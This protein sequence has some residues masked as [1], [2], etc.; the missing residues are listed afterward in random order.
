MRQ[1]IKVR[2]VGALGVE[3]SKPNLINILRNTLQQVEGETVDNQSA[4]SELKKQIA[5]SIAEMQLVKDTRSAI[6]EGQPRLFI[7]SRRRLRLVKGNADV[8]KEGN[9]EHAQPR[10][11]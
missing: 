10:L 11:C 9:Y 6:A 4:V 1:F 2:L 8:A 5:L 7:V 3:M